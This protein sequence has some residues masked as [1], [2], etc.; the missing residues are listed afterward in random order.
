MST[1]FQG[2]LPTRSWEE[3]KPAKQTEYAAGMVGSNPLE[4][5]L[6]VKKRHF[7]KDRGYDQHC[8]KLLKE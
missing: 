2:P 6:E 7:N 3:E 1:E 5:L 4:Y 8:E